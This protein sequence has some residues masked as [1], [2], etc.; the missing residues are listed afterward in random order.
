MQSTLNESAQIDAIAMSQQIKERLVDLALSDNFVS[1]SAVAKALRE[2]WE[3]TPVNGGLVGDLWVEGVFPSVSS[4]ESL[5][6]LVESGV[7]AESIMRLLDGN[8]QLPGDR[9]LYTH[10]A[11]SVSHAAGFQG[12]DEKPAIVVTAGTGAGKTESFL[13]PLLNLLASN[14]KRE[15]DQGI[16][17]LILYP[18]NALVN[19]QMER[20]YKWLQGQGANPSISC[21]HF[22][23]ET[24]ESRA[25]KDKRDF[26]AYDSCR[27]QTRQE[28]RG[29]ESHDGRKLEGE[30]RGS[31]PDIVITNYSMLEYMLCRPQ[32]QCFFGRNLQVVVLDEAHLYSGTLAAEMTLLLRRLYERCGVGSERVLQLATSA[33]IGDDSAGEA[34]HLEQFAST[35][36][37]KPKALV[38]VIQ[39]QKR[40]TRLAPL[41]VA[42]RVSLEKWL[43][44]LW[45]DKP[46]LEYDE[47]GKAQLAEWTMDEMKR[48]RESLAVGSDLAIASCRHPS[49]F[50]HAALPFD[51]TVCRLSAILYERKHLCMSELAKL[52]WNRADDAALQATRRIL[53]LAAS[54]RQAADEFPLVPHRLHLQARGS[55]RISVC[56]NGACGD[57]YKLPGLGSL[58]P[59]GNG[60]C[61]SCTHA[62][63]SVVRCDNCGTWA[64]AGMKD[65]DTGRYLPLYRKED[66]EK[67]EVRAYS[68][69]GHGKSSKEEVLNTKTG[70]PAHGGVSL[71]FI[72]D[73]RC[74]CC[75]EKLR[76]EG[77]LLG[78]SAD[79]AISVLTETV[80]T[81]LPPLPVKYNQW[82][83][84]KG[85]RLLAFSDSRG[86][87]ARLGP[88][89]GFQHEVQLF[90]AA[91]VQCIG[92]ESPAKAEELEEDIAREQQRLE[93]DPSNA[94]SKQKLMEYQRDLAALQQGGKVGDWA[95][96]LA[97]S[98][99]IQQIIDRGEPGCD[100]DNDPSTRHKTIADDP[101]KPSGWDHAPQRNWE[102]N[103]KGTRKFIEAM[104]GRELARLSY[105]GTNLQMAVMV[106][107]N[108]PGLDGIKAPDALLGTLPTEAM[109]TQLRSHWA[110]LLALLLDT[111]R[112]DGAITLGSEEYDESFPYGSQYIGHWMS[113][114]G[115][116]YKLL[117]FRG[118]EGEPG[119]P[120]YEEARQR[121][122]RFM[123]RVLLK[124]GC[125]QSDVTSLARSVM[126]AVFQQMT[127]FTF[128]WLKCEERQTRDKASVKAIRL[129]FPALTLRRPPQLFRC[130]NTSSIWTRHLC[131][132]VAT[133]GKLD[134]D[135]IDHAAADLDLRV[136]RH[137]RGYQSD[138]YNTGLWAEEHS[139]Q[140]SPEENRRLQNLFKAGARNVLSS[141]TTMELGID[142]GGLNAVLMSNV[143]PGKANYLQRA[144]RA[145]RRADGSSI[146]VT[147]ARNTPYE[148]EVIQ[149]FGDYLAKPLRNPTVSL[150][151][152]R[153]V[154]R[155]FH[156]YLLGL[157]FR[158]ITAEGAKA[159]AMDV[160]GRMG[161]F[162]GLARSQYWKPTNNPLRPEPILQSRGTKIIANQYLEFLESLADTDEWH[163]SARALIAD[164]ALASGDLQILLAD[165]SSRFTALRDRWKSSYQPVL[166]AWEAIPN[167]DTDR[168]AFANRLH[169]EL[170]A[171]H[172]ITVVAALAEEQYLPR[173]GFPIG[174][175]KLKVVGTDE[176]HRAEE[177]EQYRLARGGIQALREYVPGSALLVGGRLVISRGLLK[178]SI[179]I[180]DGPEKTRSFGVSGWFSK[181]TRG[182]FMHGPGGGASA[183]CEVCNGDAVGAKS[184]F[185]IPQHGFVTAAWESPQRHL[186]TERIGSAV[187][188]AINLR[189]T[190]VSDPAFAGNPAWA[191]YYKESGEI[192]VH[193][194]GEK[195]LGY[196]ICIACGMTES[197]CRPVAIDKDKSLPR[198]LLHHSG[199]HSPKPRQGFH[200]PKA[201]DHQNSF[202]RHQSLASK[203]IT[204]VLLL[205]FGPQASDLA[206]TLALAL[207]IAG[208][209]LLQLDSRELGH[210]V[211]PSPN[212]GHPTA[213]VYDNV[214][215]GAGHVLE[216]MK[217][218]ADW[219][220]AAWVKMAAEVMRG[221]DA[222]HESCETACMDCILSADIFDDADI[223]KL[224]RKRAYDCI[225]Q[226][227]TY[228]E[229][230]GSCGE[231][232]TESRPSRSN[233]DRK[234]RL[235]NCGF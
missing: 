225:S 50:L 3:D 31:V 55:S 23:S 5:R 76:A 58:N 82:L 104:L 30:Q 210:T 107:V 209:R 36:F 16:Q 17:C 95:A 234:S 182:H 212:G 226:S 215:G 22:T 99:I 134:L 69:S 222:H 233:A 228:R 51:E 10:Q 96:K 12:R 126:E 11:E 138:F 146:V 80:L 190:A 192:F 29:W 164:T 39:G 34:G 183:K 91:L 157:F 201:C 15:P 108:Y 25:R 61:P 196:A 38:K 90:R 13:L 189:E 178:N 97:Q 33:T 56:L 203:V 231:N 73:N 132:I 74:S 180:G 110:T 143:P 162:C 19:D 120:D 125:P 94:R 152:E 169:Y 135:Q 85:R 26:R 216:L 166:K 127:S 165:A 204:D 81:Q 119:E 208:A 27:K 177:Q 227:E 18:M 137:R 87:A 2:M 67:K 7:V 92:L 77:R 147:F 89:L 230:L 45:G 72:P 113:L 70:A 114:D 28:A 43:A 156:A 8:G 211:A 142:I 194:Q 47:F 217:G 218:N 176:R 41:A 122:T 235:S 191:A 223:K 6:S 129:H 105:G 179:G 136:G 197:E 173:Y 139:A 172:Q 193:N 21:F 141:T 48:L 46:T 131:G 100:S 155:H 221:T 86:A 149:R 35:L 68:L 232:H 84:A 75:D 66:W 186:G 159:G 206:E 83:P 150:E 202:L 171:A 40:D 167:G 111:L 79:L 116:G 224:H 174:T 123:E 168:A 57:G 198:E 188:Q 214:P 1:D 102:D 64:V 49:V 109:R 158:S 65:A 93:K 52:L 160:Y 181:C 112:M 163:V 161:D 118:V 185:L 60:V 187:V 145:G 62:C 106:E 78:Q 115:I 88:K 24:P 154:R 213:V 205:D 44:V 54:A 219:D 175:M 124:M 220:S 195:D 133:K 140:L 117:R 59:R 101:S 130:K 71:Y 153:I 103:S 98:T 128:D 229:A 207:K 121:R 151:R 148:R 9:M 32:D 20:I 199:L 144:G 4:G 14:P 200:R 37:T 63:L 184:D 53:Q 170:V 42:K